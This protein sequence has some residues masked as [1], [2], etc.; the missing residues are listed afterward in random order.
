MYELYI[1]I[2]STLIIAV[3]LGRRY[4]LSGREVRQEF[5]KHVEA[6]VEENRKQEQEE[7]KIRF[8][9]EFVRRQ[10]KRSLDVKR[11]KEEMSQADMAMSKRNW[12]LAKKHLIQ[13]IA[14]AQ[15]EFPASLM[16]ANVYVE[17]EDYRRAETLYRRLI[18]IDSQNPKIYEN[19]ARILVKKKRY[20][21][22]IQ[23]YV[24]AVE[25]DDKDEQ[26]FLALGKLYYLLMRYSVAGECF[27]QAAELKPRDVNILFL[28]AEACQADDDYENALFTYERILT[29]EPYNERAKNSS[30]EVRLQIK[31]Y[32]TF[33]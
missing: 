9:E 16:L 29:L 27:R 33:N 4:V 6:K 11:Y 26:K 32:E 8:K 7:T 18:E 5:K 12:E 20:K 17:T 3:I 31:Q 2:A 22:A 14:E 28:L 10:N 19:L 13:A 15:D 1:F 25:L 24:R 30:Q 21:E 23:A